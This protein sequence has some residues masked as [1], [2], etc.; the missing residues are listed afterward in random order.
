MIERLITL[1]ENRKQFANSDEL[2]NCLK[3]DTA[4]RNEIEALSKAFFHKIVSGCSNCYFDAYIQLISLKIDIAMDKLKCAFLLLAGALLQDSVNQ[5]IDLACSNANITDDLALY[6]LKTNPNCR[7]LF[8]TVPDNL[9]ELL[10]DY[11]L[12]GEEA[13]EAAELKAKEEAEELAAKEAKEVEELAKI[14]AEKAAKEEKITDSNVDAPVVDAT[15]QE[16]T[17]ADSE[18]AK[19]TN[20]EEAPVATT[21]KAK[22]A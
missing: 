14:E 4:L 22:K 2:F 15:M 12:P 3:T 13:E 20:V 21:Q 16:P 19:T 11:K 8:Q 1:Q 6:H 9:E 17:T 18:V 10:A 7:D 5:N